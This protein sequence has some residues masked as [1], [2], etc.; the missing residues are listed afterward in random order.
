MITFRVQRAICDK[1]SQL[2]RFQM[3]TGNLTFGCDMVIE[4][5]LIADNHLSA[6]SLQRLCVQK[7]CWLMGQGLSDY[8]VASVT[9]EDIVAFRE[10]G[11]N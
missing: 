8:C 5:R 11:Q 1:A 3:Y 10:I 9:E 6:E 4:D 7:I 2:L